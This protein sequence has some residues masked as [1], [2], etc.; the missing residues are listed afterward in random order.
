VNTRIEGELG[1]P[2]RNISSQGQNWLP[3]AN[4]Q[5]GGMQTAD[6]VAAFLRQNRYRVELYLDD[7]DPA[8]NKERFDR[9]FARRPEFEQQFGEPLEWERLDSRRACRIAI[10]TDAGI[11]TDNEN[12]AVVDWTAQ[13]ALDFYRVFGPE[14][15]GKVGETPQPES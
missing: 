4:L 12:Q 15:A 14:F 13:K 7:S 8:R 5:P 11:L 3:L 2:H 9:L 1:F 6:I 10:Y